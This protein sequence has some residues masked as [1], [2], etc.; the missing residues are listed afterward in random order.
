MRIRFAICY[1]KNKFNFI[2]FGSFFK[3]ILERQPGPK[4]IIFPKYSVNLCVIV[5]RAGTASPA[6]GFKVV[7]E[8]DRK[9]INSNVNVLGPLSGP[10]NIKQQIKV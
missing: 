7:R 5:P 9:Y 8:N 2:Y 6:D 4:L 3:T 10:Q 1:V